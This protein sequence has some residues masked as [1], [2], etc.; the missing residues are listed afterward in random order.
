[1][2]IMWKQQGTQ[3]WLLLSRSTVLF[4]LVLVLNNIFK[5]LLASK[6]AETPH[7]LLCVI[8]TSN[9]SFS[10]PACTSRVPHPCILLCHVSLCSRVAH[11]GSQYALVGLSYLEVI[12]A[13]LL[14]SV[15]CYLFCCRVPVPCSVSWENTGA[16]WE[17]LGHGCSLRAITW[18]SRVFLFFI[19]LHCARIV[20]CALK[21]L[22]CQRCIETIPS[23]ECQWEWCFHSSL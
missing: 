12:L 2:N 23:V 3:C 17:S 21:S 15:N 8:E 20:L 22:T 4:L 10:F 6:V 9:S 1:M 11:T 18:L 19:L 7:V 14:C 5:Q 13:S 16:F